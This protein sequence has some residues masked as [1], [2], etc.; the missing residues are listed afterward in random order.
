MKDHKV[1]LY[2]DGSSRPNPGKSGWGAHG[3]SYIDIVPNIRKL[4][5]QYLT[6]TGY[7][8][9]KDTNE[10]TT[11][12]APIQYYDFCV[13]E[14]ECTTNNGAELH[15]FYRSLKFFQ[16]HDISDILIYTDSEYVNRGIKEYINI[17]IK[18]NWVRQDGQSIL[19]AHVWKEI[20]EILEDFRNRNIAFRIEWIKGH[21]DSYGNIIADKLA[22]IAALKGYRVNEYESYVVTP[23]EGYGKEE[24][25]KH[26]FICFRRMYFSSSTCLP[27]A[28]RYFI[29]NPASNDDDDIGRKISEAAYAVILNEDPDPVLEI[30]K[31]RQ[32]EISDNFTKTVM[33]RLDRLYDRNVYPY[34]AMYGEDCLMRSNQYTG[35][36][37]FVDDKN[38][39]HEML[40]PGLTPR[41]MSIFSVLE[42]LL[43]QYKNNSLLQDHYAVDI[44]DVFYDIKPTKNGFR[45]ILKPE[46]GVGYKST[47]IKLTINH[48]GRDHALSFPLLLGG[49]ILP[50]NN[51][52][53]LEDSNPKIKIVIWA[54]SSRVFQYATITEV[55]GA[56]GIWSN[57]HSSKILIT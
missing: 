26:P 40:P 37:D 48:E 32:R 29:A 19:M 46:Y 23:A 5:D 45:H 7:Y 50:R 20:L 9:K 52:K 21:A 3:Y 8:N 10:E 38:I 51:L 34:I 13:Y 6:P 28:G 31:R 14:N 22:S 11:Y 4:N 25:P 57:Y 27:D 12:V 36:L 1:V 16:Q 55:D 15:A 41:A 30:V 43:L 24:I 17:W 53:K 49:D 2:I 33:L 54:E 42:T 56:I 18:N 44:T 35:N 39:T 47:E